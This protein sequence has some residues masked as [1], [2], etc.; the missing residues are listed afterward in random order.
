LGVASAR[1][2]VLSFAELAGDESEFFQ[3]YFD[4][5]PLLRREALR[6]DPASVLSIGDLDEILRSQAIRFPHLKI[7]RQGYDV[8]AFEFTQPLQVAGKLAS[9]AIIPDRVVEYF[10]DGCTIMWPAMHHFRPNMRALTLMLSDKFSAQ[11]AV[12]A[13]LTPA[14]KRGLAPHSDQTDVFVVQ[15]AGTKHWRVWPVPEARK[16]DALSYSASGDELGPPITETTLSPGDILYLPNG[17]PH[18]AASGNA[19]SLHLAV[20]VWP[21]RWAELLKLIVAEIVDNDPG[22]RGAAYLNQSRHGS[23]AESLSS[24][25]AALTGRLELIDRDDAIRRL[26]A[27][28]R[29]QADLLKPQPLTDLLLADSITPATNV[30]RNPH[31][32]IEDGGGSGESKRG[33]VSIDGTLY[34]MPVSVASALLRLGI[35][36]ELPAGEF[37]NGR[38]VDSSVRVVQHLCRIGALERR[39]PGAGD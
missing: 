11:T 8:P 14:N 35:E 4:K 31:A 3:S 6:A 18:A 27:T 22:F 2:H 15:L 21:H 17:T 23:L 16:G 12:T 25:V 24:R 34:E 36:D 1:G 9:D 7:S 5:A 37:L 32:A 10:R 20:I 33:R 26:I 39:R 19:I 38:P 13:L 30:R 29:P 28:A